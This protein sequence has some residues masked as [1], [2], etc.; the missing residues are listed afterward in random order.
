M[1]TCKLFIGSEHFSCTLIH[2]DHWI[3]EH[4]NQEVFHRKHLMVIIDGNQFFFGCV[5]ILEV[6]DLPATRY[7][8][9]CMRGNLH[10]LS[11][12]YL[13]KCRHTKL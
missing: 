5:N 7:V 11:V 10:S 4:S 6:F 1:Q 3:T 8:K 12:L 9:Y 13:I 2:Q